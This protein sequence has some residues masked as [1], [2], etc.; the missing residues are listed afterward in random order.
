[1]A[2]DARV[3]DLLEAAPSSCPLLTPSNGCRGRF[4]GKLGRRIMQFLSLGDWFFI[5]AATGTLLLVE[6]GVLIIVGVI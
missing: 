2:P 1:M 6:V 5:S 4:F 3:K